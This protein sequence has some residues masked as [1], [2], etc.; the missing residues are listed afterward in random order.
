MS[1]VEPFNR[2]NTPRVAQ[3]SQRSN[4]FNLRT[5]RYTEAEIESLAASGN[6]FTFSFTLEDKF[7]DNGLICVIVLKKEENETL[8]IETWL[9]SCRVLKRGMENFVLNFICEF[10]KNKGYTFLKGEFIPTPKNELVKN[11]YQKL[12]FEYKDG[13]W[14]INLKLFSE[15]K[16]FIKIKYSINGKARDN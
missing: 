15:R 2:F 6:Y 11:H 4:Q 8:F 10:S 9:M 13:Y 16:C 7:G 3:L 14:I 1:L 5:K 12:G